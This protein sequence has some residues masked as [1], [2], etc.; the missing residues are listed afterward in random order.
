MKCVGNTGIHQK[1]IENEK[2][3]RE[4]IAVL[5]KDFPST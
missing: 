4:L 5:V 1:D 2:K 3:N